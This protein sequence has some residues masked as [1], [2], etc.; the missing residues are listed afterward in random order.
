MIQNKSSS[1][2]ILQ[3]PRD[4]ILIESDGPFTKVNGAKYSPEY[5]REEYSMI[6]DYFNFLIF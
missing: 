2:K 1:R 6:K 3:I 5:L 4:R